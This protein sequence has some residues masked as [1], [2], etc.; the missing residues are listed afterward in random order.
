MNRLTRDV[1]DMFLTCLTHI[2]R[3]M[4]MYYVLHFSSKSL[5]RSF[6]ECLNTIRG[7]LVAGNERRE[8]RNKQNIIKIKLSQNMATPNS[9]ISCN[10][11]HPTRDTKKTK[12]NTD[13]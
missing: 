9:K 5:V 3:S 10:M 11:E 12:P 7:V 1:F 8:D 13:A 2:F 6:S 4:L